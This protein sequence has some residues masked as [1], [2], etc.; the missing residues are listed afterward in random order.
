MNLEKDNE[1]GIKTGLKLLAKSSIIVFIGLFLS[2][3][4]FYG[5]RIV[6]ARHYGP[7]IYG[8]FALSVMLFSWF[9]VISN[10][11]IKQGLLRHV[12]LLRGK[13]EK[14]KIRGLIKIS[15]LILI[16]TSIIAGILLF[17]F[18]EFIALKIFSDPNL[19][20]FLKIFSFE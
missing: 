18:S 8:L 17:F 7:E 13:G 1:A 12:S 5:Y 14:G 19:I 10:L 6:I 3:I 16:I 9:R 11:G 4:I 15:F 20:I 2:K